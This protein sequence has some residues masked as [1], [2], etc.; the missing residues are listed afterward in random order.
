MSSESSKKGDGERDETP[1]W[2]FSLKVYA[3]P[4]VERALLRLQDRDGLDVN[5]VLLCAYAGHHGARFTEAALESLV[6]H[7]TAWRQSAVEPLRSARRAL[8]H[9][10]GAV[11]AVQSRNLRRLVKEAELEA[12]RIQQDMLFGLLDHVGA[13]DGRSADRAGL[14]RGNLSAYVSRVATELSNTVKS[15]LE[16]VVE[17]AAI[18]ED[19][20]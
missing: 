3:D 5:M 14:I 6:A 13:V 16:I 10:V 8:K 19:F 12:E 18:Q 20:F 9:D 11:S 7:A 4:R 2:R 17:S 1:F 15:D